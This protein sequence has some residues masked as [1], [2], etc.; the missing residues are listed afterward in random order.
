MT[1]KL[2]KVKI[3]HAYR[4][5]EQCI[6]WFTYKPA[7]TNY[8]KHEVLEEVEAELPDGITY[9]NEWKTFSDRGHDCQM[10]TCN[11]GSLSLVSSER[12]I[13]WFK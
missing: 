8:Y 6:R 2:Y 4:A 5:D 3:Y 10:V 12:I 11:D 9:E 7:D 1:V 13:N